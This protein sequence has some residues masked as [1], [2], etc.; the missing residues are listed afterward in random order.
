MCECVCVIFCRK[1]KDEFKKKNN[2]L[3]EENARLQKENARLVE[4]ATQMFAAEIETKNNSIQELDR[5]SKALIAGYDEIQ[6]KFR[7]VTSSSS[8]EFT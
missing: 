8:K 6:A 7:Y 3:I 2:E 1:S 5:R 4:E